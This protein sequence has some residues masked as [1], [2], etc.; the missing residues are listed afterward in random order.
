[1]LLRIFIKSDNLKPAED[2][3]SL[4]KQPAGEVHCQKPDINGHDRRCIRN[5]TVNVI[6]NLHEDLHFWAL[7]WNTVCSGFIVLEFVRQ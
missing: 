5:M 7:V 6:V 2:N 1:M 4:D 3:R